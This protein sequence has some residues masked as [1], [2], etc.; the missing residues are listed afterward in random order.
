MQVKNGLRGSPEN[1]TAGSVPATATTAGHRRH[2][3]NIVDS[4][5][6]SQIP[7]SKVKLQAMTIH[8]KQQHRKQSDRIWVSTAKGPARKK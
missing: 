6:E 5:K 3:R 2:L 4:V 1:L 8:G 7:T